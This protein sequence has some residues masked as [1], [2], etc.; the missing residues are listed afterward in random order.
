MTHQ[1]RLIAGRSDGASSGRT[2]NLHSESDLQTS[3]M[4]SQKSSTRFYYGNVWRKSTEEPNRTTETIP[5]FSCPPQPTSSSSFLLEQSVPQTVPCTP[6][7]PQPYSTGGMVPSSAQT[8]PFLMALLK[9]NI[10][11]CIGSRPGNGTLNQNPPNITALHTRLQ[12]VKPEK[13]SL[14]VRAPA[15]FPA[16]CDVGTNQRAQ[17]TLPLEQ[18][19]S[20]LHSLHQQQLDLLN[21]WS[22]T[23]PIHQVSAV[24]PR[25]VVGQNAVMKT[26]SSVMDDGELS[27]VV[28][29]LLRQQA[30]YEHLCGV[31]LCGQLPLPPIFKLY[32]PP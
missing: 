13:E 24:M 15:K 27:P 14:P 30:M 21:C 12:N 9:L 22:S 28:A 7:P 17:S 23:T 11:G 20:Q 29:E 26:G 19:S 25:P 18:Q 31:Y 10:E 16:I 32:T 1:N 8:A 3:P 5:T 6:L 2:E 4:Q